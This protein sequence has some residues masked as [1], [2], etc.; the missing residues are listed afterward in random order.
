MNDATRA[1]SLRR[2]LIVFLI[3][4]V[5]SVLATWPLARELFT[6]DRLADRQLDDYVYWWDFWWTHEA[7]LVRHVDPLF[8]GDVFAPQGAS[9]VASPLA[10]PLGVLSLPLQALFGGLHGSV[11]AVKLFGFLLFPL[12]MHGVSRLVR[13]FGIPLLPSLL[14][15]A[16]FAFTPFRIVQLGRIHYLAGALVPWFLDLT[17]RAVR[18][19]RPRWFAAAAGCYALAGAIDPSLLPEMVLCSGALL[20]YLTRNGIS[21]RRAVVRILGCG[22]AGMVLLSPLLVRFLAE[23]KGNTGADVASRLAY[24]DEPDMAQRV[25]SPDLD[26]LFWMTAPALHERVLMDP[27]EAERPARAKSSARL[28]ADVYDSLRPNSWAQPIEAAV[29]GA[30]IAAVV[31]AA[32]LAASRRGGAAFLVLAVVGFVLALGPQRTFGATVVEMPYAW[33]ARAVPGMAA[34]RYPAANLRLFQ[35]G[36]AVAA[37]LALAEGRRWLVV[38]G[39]VVAAAF[40]VVS[41]LRPLRFEPIHFEEAH[42]LIASDPVGG[43]VLELPARTEIVLR[44]SALGQLVHHRQLMGGPLTRVS[45]RS[46]Q[47]FNDEPVVR[48]L[49]HPI[50][51]ALAD[52]LELAAEIA[53][54]RAILARYDVRYIVVRRALFEQ[55]PDAFDDF[56]AYVTAHQFHVQST[57]EGHLLICID[58]QG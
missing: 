10:L 22:L 44:R 56:I 50:D 33:L 39:T 17:L 16:L 58:R 11:I 45:A 15:G 43:R 4:T 53:E 7:L 48:R 31:A 32:L 34:G 8:C 27:T 49:L 36:I 19:G 41:P 1:G 57:R 6:A 2:E 18:N 9:L 37:A 21:F 46:L 55:N 28:N 54:N 26:A 51:P 40:L 52:P 5:A 30:V 20:W 29:A 42:A 3:A 14:A 25:L 35:L 47:F 12:A 13:S 38:T 23:M 24:D